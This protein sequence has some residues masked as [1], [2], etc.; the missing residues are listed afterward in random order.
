MLIKD[1]VVGNWYKGTRTTYPL[2][3]EGRS[4]RNASDINSETYDF[5]FKSETGLT[6][7]YV[8]VIPDWANEVAIIEVKPLSSLELELL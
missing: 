1:L 4:A 8:C 6:F 7:L 5:Y 3:F 2:R